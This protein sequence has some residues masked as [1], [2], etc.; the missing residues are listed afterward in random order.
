MF[1]VTKYFVPGTL[2][3]HVTSVTIADGVSVNSVTIG[4]VRVPVV[5]DGVEH[6]LILIS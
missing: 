5:V 1:K 4:T 6:E 3:A 2:C